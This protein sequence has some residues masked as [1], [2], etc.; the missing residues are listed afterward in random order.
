M[1]TAV[2]TVAALPDE[3]SGRITT[4]A[5]GAVLVEAALI[6]RPGD[7]DVRGAPVPPVPFT[8]PTGARYHFVHSRGLGGAPDGKPTNGMGA[9]LRFGLEVRSL[10]TVLLARAVEEALRGISAHAALHEAILECRAV[11]LAEPSAPRAALVERLALDLLRAGLSVT[12]GPSWTP[13]PEG[14]DLAFGVHGLGGD[15]TAAVLEDL[16]GAGSFRRSV[17]RP[18]S[19]ARAAGVR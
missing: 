4:R 17:P 15:D 8:A 7:G 2:A 18:L 14:V 12:F 3:P 13:L 11:R 5:A 10:E 6:G 1:P 19:A 16:A 9:P